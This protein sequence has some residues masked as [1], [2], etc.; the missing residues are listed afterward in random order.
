ML[1]ITCNPDADLRS[2]V[3]I[4]SQ[5]DELREEAAKKAADLTR[6]ILGV[7]KQHFQPGMIIG[8]RLVGEWKFITSTQRND[9]YT[10]EFVSGETVALKVLQDQMQGKDPGQ[11]LSV[12]HVSDRDGIR[13]LRHLI[14]FSTSSTSLALTKIRPRFTVLWSWNERGRWADPN[15]RSPS[16]GVEIMLIMFT[17]TGSLPIYRTVMR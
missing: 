10:T 2:A 12:S 3:Q 7:T 1:R 14:A 5:D 9:I 16:R 4:L 13:T 6:W 17:A 15:V 8:R 11:L